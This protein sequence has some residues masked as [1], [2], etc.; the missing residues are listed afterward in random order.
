VKRRAFIT[1]LG[2]AASWPLAASAQQPA[3]PVVGWLG[4]GS[5]DALAG[6]VAAFRKGLSEASFVE[7]LNVTIEYRW[8]EGE[9]DR[10]PALAASLVR[11]PV[12]VILASGGNLPTLAA[13]TATSTTP[14][15]FLHG[16]SDPVAAGL[17]AS[18]NRPG[19][20]VTG[21][22]FLAAE[23]VTKQLS[24]LRELVPAATMIAMLVNPNSPIADPTA[25]DLQMAARSLGLQLRVLTA[26]TEHS[27]DEVFASFGQQPADA[28]LVQTEP[29]LGI[30]RGQIA[31]LATRYVI[32]T[33]SSLEGF[34]AAGGLITYG[35]SATDAYR[36]AGIYVGRILK[37]EKPGDLPV[38]QP[39]K[40]KL[41]INLKTA[42]ALGL[43][44]PDRLLALAD[45]LIE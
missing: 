33:I 5:P 4:S 42:K 24:L 3:L 11:H 9:Y 17:V 43:T 34:A 20:N 45:E 36:Q 22:N 44:V 16:G 32:P 6:Q 13:K 12:A 25:G 8:A 15:V 27:I 28:L 39:T 18:F 38:L 23:L 37:G 40:F 19:G 21:V 35:A 29:F 41:V 30:R 26:S 7:G 1:L 14:I 10:L 31:A 2:G